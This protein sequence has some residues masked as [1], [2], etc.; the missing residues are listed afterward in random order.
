MLIIPFIL[1]PDASAMTGSPYEPGSCRG[2]K[3]CVSLE[4]EDFDMIMYASMGS[5]MVILYDKNTSGEIY[6][7][8]M[9]SL[10][11]RS[12]G[13]VNDAIV[14]LSRN[15]D[16]SRFTIRKASIST[17]WFTSEKLDSVYVLLP[18]YALREAEAPEYVFF[19]KEGRLRVRI[20]PK[21]RIHIFDRD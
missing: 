19:E 8:S 11:D 15:P 1:I 17:G 7:T 5:Q 20:K 2:I 13:S 9:A 18:R 3:L 12:R 16:Y 10:Y 21:V 14:F 4:G 6:P